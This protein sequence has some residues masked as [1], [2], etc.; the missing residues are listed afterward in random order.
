MIKKTYNLENQERLVEITT[1]KYND[2][3]YALLYNEKNKE[4]TIGKIKDNSIK[5]VKE[6]EY[7]YEKI[8][9]LLFNNLKNIIKENN[10]D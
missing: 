7:D 2:E 3:T 4:I 6:S 8:I 9:I 10:N 5:N 1:T